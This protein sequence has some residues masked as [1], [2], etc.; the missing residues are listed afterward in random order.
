LGKVE[1]IVLVKPI[2][3]RKKNSSKVEFCCPNWAYSSIFGLE[4]EVVASNY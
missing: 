2:H 3:M 4:I 1:I